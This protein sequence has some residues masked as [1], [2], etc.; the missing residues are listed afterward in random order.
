MLDINNYSP[1]T[2]RKLRED[3]TNFNEADFWAGASGHDG[4]KFIS[5]TTATTPAEGLVFTVVQ[6]IEDAVFITLT[7]NMSGS[8]A[9]VT[10]SAGTA[11]CGRFS[12]VTLASGKVIAYQGV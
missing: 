2:G 7:G 4:S 6:V 9:G 3:N 8:I 1:Q 12:A 11:F 10:F 5:D